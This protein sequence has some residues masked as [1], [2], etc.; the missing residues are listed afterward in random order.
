MLS[1]VEGPPVISPLDSA[2]GDSMAQSR[3]KK[4][5]EELPLPDAKLMISR[6]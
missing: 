5:P 2:Q 4:N 1:E 6:P 3:L